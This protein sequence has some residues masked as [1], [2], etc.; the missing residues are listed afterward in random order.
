MTDTDNYIHVY[1]QI[2]EQWYCRVVL[3]KVTINISNSR[4]RFSV[5]LCFPLPQRNEDQIGEPVQD[6]C[7][8][9]FSCSAKKCL[10][11]VYTV[12]QIRQVLVW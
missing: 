10:F 1:I 9:Y 4:W 8:L 2:K 3:A 11:L 12:G 5:T 7:N 6:E